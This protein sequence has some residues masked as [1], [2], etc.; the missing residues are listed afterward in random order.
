[1]K[2][3]ILSTIIIL[4]FKLGLSQNITISGY[5]YDANTK[6]K[7]IGA[8]VFEQNSKIGTTTNNYGFYSITVN[9]L[10]TISLIINYLGYNRFSEKLTTTK[11]IEKNIFLIPTDNQISEVVIISN[12]ITKNDIG[13]INI[14]PKQISMVPS[15]GGEKDIFKVFQLMPGVMQ[16]SEGKS[17]LYIRGSSPDQNLILLD[18]MPLYYAEHLGGF[19]SVFNDDAINN[20]K[21]IKGSIPARYGGRLSSVMDIRLKD[22]SMTKLNGSFTVG[23]ITSKIELDGPIIKNK[24]SFLFSARRTLFDILILP[25]AKGM[26]N[27]SLMGYS[28]YDINSKIHIKANKNNSIFLS[29]YSGQDNVKINDKIDNYEQ[30]YQNLVKQNWGNYVSSFRWNHIYSNKLF[31]NFVLGIS[32]FQYNSFEKTATGF[33]TIRSINSNEFNSAIFDINSKMDF[34]YYLNKNF[35]FN[36]GINGIYHTFNPATVN[37]FNQVE[38]IVKTDTSFSSIKINST[39]I[40]AY[41]ETNISISNIIKSNIGL[42]YNQYFFNK[43]NFQSIEPR[44]L[45]S[46]KTSKS[47]LLKLSYTYLEQNIH[48]LC[49]FFILNMG[50]EVV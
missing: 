30:F 8:S 44:I 19:L 5:I 42:R 22:G 38:N 21:L 3:I 16:G 50:F 41:L 13:V 49:V 7:L 28:F 32:Q 17:G 18:D 35:N 47:S 29:F 2:T 39:E 9:N 43:T 27:N 25:I 40:S 15:L 34:E 46:I 12:N 10:D 14:S 4:T 24:A 48:M 26:I 36:F 33:D 20:I 31:S 23:L 45:T 11:N 37:Y 6:E 1:M